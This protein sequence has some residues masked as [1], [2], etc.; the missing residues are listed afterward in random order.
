[1]AR[2][3]VPIAS[4]QELILAAAKGLGGQDAAA[5]AEVL[6]AGGGRQP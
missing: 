4:L 2:T 6:A 5:I 1:M 3:K